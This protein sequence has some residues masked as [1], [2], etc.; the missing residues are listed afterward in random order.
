MRDVLKSLLVAYPATVSNKSLFASASAVAL[1]ADKTLNSVASRAESRKF[2]MGYCQMI[3][4]STASP[5]SYTYPDGS[6]VSF[7]TKA[8]LVADCVTKFDT[9]WAEI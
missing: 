6:T 3:K 1:S 9:Y 4:N 7:N 5:I 2:A 8:E